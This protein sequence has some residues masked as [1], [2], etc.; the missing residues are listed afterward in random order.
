M[1]GGEHLLAESVRVG[2]GAWVLATVFTA[3]MAEVLLLAV[4]GAS[5]AGQVE[6]GAV[7]ARDSISD[8]ADSIQHLTF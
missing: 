8:H 2:I 5:I 4:G 7:G 1:V 3:V 6:A